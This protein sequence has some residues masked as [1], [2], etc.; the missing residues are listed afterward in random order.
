MGSLNTLSNRKIGVPMR[1]LRPSLALCA[2]LLLGA[3]LFLI[4]VG[5]GGNRP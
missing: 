4:S 2:A 3:H 5:T 1:L